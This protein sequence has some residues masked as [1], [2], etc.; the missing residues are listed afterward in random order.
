MNDSVPLLQVKDLSVNFRT[1]FG[2]TEAVKRISFQVQKGE[3]LA[4]V[5]ES[6]WIGK[7]WP[8]HCAG[9]WEPL[10]GSG[11]R[12]GSGSAKSRVSILHDGTGSPCAPSIPDR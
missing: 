11:K 9:A 3:T 6:G 5:G 7:A 8:G 2:E 1:P 10:H 12:P 4:V